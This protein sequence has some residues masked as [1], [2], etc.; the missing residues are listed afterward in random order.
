MT[1]A[2]SPIQIET[3]YSYAEQIYPEECCGI[4]LGTIDGSIRTVIEVILTVNAWQKPELVENLGDS[5]EVLK[6]K[7][8]RYTIDPQDIFQT[9]K[10]GRELH[11]EIIGF[12]HSH[13]DNP[14]I[15][16]TCDRDRAWEVYSY[17]IVSVLQGKVNDFQSWVLDSQGLFQ[18]EEIT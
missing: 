7:N 3:I 6:T 14:A 11:L 9:Q 17:P 10:R 12:F 8:S 15:P 5:I 1:I 16:S 2:I 18:R 4:L 13:P